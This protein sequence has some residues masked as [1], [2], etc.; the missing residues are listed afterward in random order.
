MSNDPPAL[1]GL[2]AGLPQEAEYHAV[3]AAVTATERGRWFL[4]EFASRNGHADAVSLLN[5]MA[6][7]EAAVRGDASGVEIARSLAIS[8]A[9]ERIADLAIELRDRAADSAL[10]DA[11]DTAVRELN[12]AVVIAVPNQDVEDSAA[13]PSQNAAMQTVPAPPPLAAGSPLDEGSPPSADGGDLE[14]LDRKKPSQTA[15]A[16]ATSSSALG[17]EAETACESRST[18]SATIMPRHDYEAAVGLQPGEPSQN[19]PRWYIEPPDF[20]FHSSQREKRG[21]DVNSPGQGGLM[22]SSGPGAQLQ[23][24]PQDDPADL[25]VA[26]PA[27]GGILPHSAP[28]PPTAMP[29]PVTAASASADVIQVA[30]PPPQSPTGPTVRAMRPAP[31]DPLAA[32]R[33]LSAEELIALF[34]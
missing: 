27:R 18:P 10:C 30:N 14:L 31:A 19:A 17:D 2:A 16:L 9:A 21:P 34:G 5:A 12:E 22:H 24:G 8:A 23:P 25:F 29:A 28:V 7:S 15:A 33:A 26:T 13:V 11:L 3:Y 32:L 20:V 4:T 6:G 1:S